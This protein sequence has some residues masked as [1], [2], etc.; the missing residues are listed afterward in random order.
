MQWIAQYN[1]K[2]IMSRLR[3]KATVFVCVAAVLAFLSVVCFAEQSG[4]ASSVYARQDTWQATMAATR[5]RY[6]AW[7]A[8]NLGGHVV[9]GPWHVTAPMDAPTF[10][11][12]HFPEQKVDFHARNDADR[13]IWLRN[14]DLVD[15]AVHSLQAGDR[16][17]VYLARVL[18]ADAPTTVTAGFGSDDGI[19]VWLNGNLVLS[20]DVPRVAAADQDT[21]ALSLQAGENMLLIKIYN[22]SGGCGFY[23]A[24]ANDLAA[25]LWQQ[26]KADFPLETALMERDLRSTSPLSWFTEPDISGMQR[27]MIQQAL[28]NREEGDTAL[29]RELSSLSNES[30][31][32]PRW[33]ELYVRACSMLNVQGQL[34]RV[35]F[36]ALRRAI[37]HLTAAYP[38]QYTDGPEFR[39]RLDSFESR[40]EALR[41]GFEQG[42][43]GAMADVE[44]LLTLQR[45][46]LLANPLLDFDEVV[47][48]RRS[49][50]NLGLPQNWQ[51]NCSL[52]RRGY[53]NEFARLKLFETD[54]QP[55]LVY[56]PERDVFVG[57]LDLHFDGSRFLFSMLGTH[58]RWQIWEMNVDGNGLRQV[59]TG[60]YPDVDNYDA[61]YLPDG[62]VIFDSTRVF[63]GIPCVGG[64][65]AVANLFIMDA[66]G[67]NVRQLCFDQDHNWGPTVL[68][69]GRVL[70]T[71]WEYSDTPHYFTRLLFHMNPDGTNQVEYYGSNSYWP[72]SM[73]YARAIPGHPTKVVTI[74]SGHHGVPR[75]GE[76][77]ILDPAKGRHEAD[78]VVQRIPGH[79]EPVEPVIVDQLVDAVWPKFLHPWPLSEDFFVVSCKPT[80]QS[81]WG[82]YLVDTFDNML[83]LHEEP[84][85]ALFEP[86]PL[87][88]KP[89]PP[90]IPDRV[91]LDKDYATVYLMDVY[92]GPGLRNVPRGTVDSLRLYAFHYAYQRMGGHEH[93]GV[94]GPWDVRRILGTVPVLE[95]GSA[96]FKVP[97]NTPI[98]VQPLDKEGQALQVMRS[99][100]TA[101]PGEVLSCVGCH[102]PQNTAPPTQL[103]QAARRSPDD[104]A[105]W[106]GAARGFSFKHEVQPVLDRHCVGCHGA[107][108]ITDGRPDFSDQLLPGSGNFTPSYLALHPYVRR[109][110]P[111]SDYHVQIPLEWHAETS[112]LIQMLRKGHGGVQLDDEA[113]D[114][115][116]TWIDLNVPDHGRW[117]DHAP[118]PDSFDVRRA[119]MRAQYACLPADP[120]EEELTVAEYPRE[121]VKHEKPVLDIA[122]PEVQGWPFDV[123]EAAARQAAGSSEIRRTIDLGEGV[124]M[125]FVLIPAG[126]FVMGGDRHADELPLA[127]VTIDAPFWLGVT[128]VTN[129]QYGRFNPDHNSRYINQHHK[130]HTTAGY[131]ANRP[132]QPV[133]RVNWHE[134][135]GF[136]NWLSEQVGEVATL[137]TEAQWEWACRAGSG[138]PLF[139]GDLDA[140]FSA[141][142]NLADYSM[143]KLAV[144]GVD[145]Q[146][147][148][149]PNQ[150]QDFL[151]KDARFDDGERI[152]CA[153]GQYGANPWGLKDM[154]GNVAEWTLSAYRPYPYQPDDGRN[155]SDAEGKRVVRGGS[156]RDRPFRAR[157]AFRQAYHPWQGVF[158][159]G[160]RVMMPYTEPQAHLAAE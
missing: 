27:A 104:I 12:V 5:A 66:N 120:S 76:L 93:V 151:P 107:E 126:E 11:D 60:E 9:F 108:E 85:Y 71:R 19:Q 50:G 113:W 52:P 90:A 121:F 46:A 61:C 133:I 26:M 43:A 41:T 141:Y 64:S 89:V 143:R 84:G 119:E 110:G 6:Q 59:T 118:I 115:L 146:P 23:F 111:E 38:E 136:T 99:W 127:K 73:F 116:I 53:D 31:D 135:L 4:E 32:S 79:G 101:M 48:V 112:E 13:R 25:T 39:R 28:G 103:T 86:V 139:Y 158:N 148:P 95:D 128:E 21:V 105:P 30:G 63:Q 144:S 117:S 14:T 159:V 35:N 40:L 130:D 47:L 45:E 152:V 37:D 123:S 10:D 67:G 125:E 80:A 157:S 36:A 145:P 153:V 70:F 54:A 97:A 83:L 77:I 56:R 142:A 92:E 138:A 3:F 1:R 87:R 68:N 29:R 88:Q 57:D 24:P 72:N 69:N 131:P 102:E 106:Y 74:V 18:S 96:Y 147:I 51:G 122:A 140:D 134:A 109:P 78:G 100:F 94:E 58:D 22:I 82:L 16:T 34:D 7:R 124:S 33:L 137:P 75:M 65:D 17:A 42:E 150:Y 49:E 62:R 20:K 129:E 154:H 155:A 156:W 91:N 8:E 15:G 132:D 114:R 149:N 2:I 160:F 55:S 44:A 98:A 81:P